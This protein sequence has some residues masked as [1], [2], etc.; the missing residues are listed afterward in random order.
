MKFN[1]LIPELDVEDIGKS[2]EFYVTVLGFDI[3]YLREEEGFAFL[4]KG[5]AQLMLDSAQHGRR[6]D[7]VEPGMRGR[8]VNLQIE[9][10][11]LDRMLDALAVS[12]TSLKIPLEEKYYRTPEGHVGQRQCVVA[13]PDG[14]LLRFFE[15]LDIRP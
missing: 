1:A 7:A 8:G 9:V 10:S 3:A 11:D 15:N 13:D 12:G 5:E 14:Y 4:T 2:L 6:F